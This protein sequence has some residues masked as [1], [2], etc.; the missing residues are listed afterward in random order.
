MNELLN[1]LVQT[2]QSSSKYR[3]IAPGFIRCV[4]AQA[5]EHQGRLKDAIKATKNKLHQIG[6]AYLRQPLDYDRWLERL[7]ISRASGSDELRLA[8]RSLMRRHASTRERL[9]VLERFY[10][11]V[12]DGVAPPKRVLDIACGLHPLAIPWMPLSP[13]AQYAGVDIYQDMSDFLSA[14]IALMG[15]DGTVLAQ[16]ALQAGPLGCADVAFLLKAIPPL[17]QW[18]PLAGQRLLSALD[19]R[20]LIVSFPVRSL[21]GSAKGMVEH[22]EARFQALLNGK[23]WSVR[24][25]LFPSEL[26]FRVDK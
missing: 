10:D 2:V 16:D 3:R 12:L 23:P 9:P 7:A 25:F 26:V 6:G 8:C 5:L 18:N 15:L 11:T 24:R 13:G 19:A 20:H 1:R 4:G 14:F 21:A 22:Y 17:E